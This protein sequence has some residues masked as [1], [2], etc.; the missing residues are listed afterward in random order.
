MRKHVD[1][2]LGPGDCATCG[3][4]HVVQTKRHR[5][6]ATHLNLADRGVDSYLPMILEVPPPRVGSAVQ[7]LFSGY[8][9]VRSSSKRH[10]HEVLRCPGVKGFI[11]FGGIHGCVGEA[12]IVLLRGNEGSDGVIRPMVPLQKG[13]SVRISQGAFQG[14]SAILERDIPARGRVLVLLELLSRMTP[15]EIPN[16]WIA[17]S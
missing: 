17:R 16:R 9:F 6:K 3:S 8:L 15:I 2:C 12:D 4:W 5:E 14:L 7:P 10:Y 13:R 1:P 11:S